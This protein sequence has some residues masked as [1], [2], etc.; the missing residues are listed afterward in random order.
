MAGGREHRFALLIAVAGSLV[1]V[2]LLVKPSWFLTGQTVSD[3]KTHQ[4]K[5]T[6]YSLPPKPE[7]G[8][9]TDKGINQA[10]APHKAEKHSIAQVKII[11]PVKAVSPRQPSSATDR[12]IKDRNG[13]KHGYYIQVGAFKDV[14]KAKKLA[15]SLQH[16]GWHVQ[17]ITKENALHAVLVGP[18]QTRIKAESTKLKLAKQSKV[19]GFIVSIKPGN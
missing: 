15:D 2:L 6:A 18:L 7:R 9:P 14:A 5:T 4:S 16:A 8:S 1:L 17:T 3:S 19:K 10:P 11:P 13:L 12:H